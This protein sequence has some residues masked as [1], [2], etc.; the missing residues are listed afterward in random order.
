MSCNDGLNLDGS[1]EEAEKSVDSGYILQVKQT[2][3]LDGLNGSCERKKGV[4]NDRSFGL[5][6]W[7]DKAAIN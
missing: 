5:S 6:R 7:K 2:R 3:V 4:Q 1:H